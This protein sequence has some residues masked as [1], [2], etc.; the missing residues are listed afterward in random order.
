[1]PLHNCHTA[2]ASKW[3]RIKYKTQLFSFQDPLSSN[4]YLSL[5]S[6]HLAITATWRHLQFFLISA[7]GWKLLPLPKNTVDSHLLF[8]AHIQSDSPQETFFD[9]Q[10]P[11][12]PHSPDYIYCYLSFSLSILSNFY[13]MEKGWVSFICVLSVQCLVAGEPVPWTAYLNVLATRYLSADDTGCMEWHSVNE[14]I[15][16]NKSR[17]NSN[18][19]LNG[20]ILSIS[21]SVL[22]GLFF[23]Q[24]G[25]AAEFEF[26][27][28]LWN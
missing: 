19:P 5:Q 7:P 12:Y 24:L 18:I 20:Y 28:H 17:K 21:S 11:Q 4:P 2:L 6:L 16:K 1:M 15:K 10:R 23:L 3:T 9:L 13:L 14:G 25:A 8:K 26:I 27:L 22:T